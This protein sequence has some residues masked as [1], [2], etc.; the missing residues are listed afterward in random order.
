MIVTTVSNIHQTGVYPDIISPYIKMD[1]DAIIRLLDKESLTFA[2]GALDSVSESKRDRI[3]HL[4]EATV[5]NL[6]ENRIR[7]RIYSAERAR[8]IALDAWDRANPYPRTVD[9]HSS[10][11]KIPIQYRK[12]DVRPINP[13]RQWDLDNWSIRSTNV[14]T[15]RESM[16][17][18][19]A[20]IDRLYYWRQ[21]TDARTNKQNVADYKQARIAFLNSDAYRNARGSYT[22]EYN[23]IFDQL[24]YN[25]LEVLDEPVEDILDLT[26]DDFRDAYINMLRTLPSDADAARTHSYRQVFDPDAIYNHLSAT[27]LR[28][29]A[30]LAT[31]LYNDRRT[32][33][34]GMYFIL[35]YRTVRSD[36][37]SEFQSWV[38]NIRNLQAAYSNALSQNRNRAYLYDDDEDSFMSDVSISVRQINRNQPHVGGFFP[39]Y[40]LDKALND[41][42]GYG[43]MELEY[44]MIDY[45]NRCGIYAPSDPKRKSDMS[46]LH[47]AI[48]ES[49]GVK[50]VHESA[51]HDASAIPVSKL[52]EIALNN[53]IR[54][55]LVDGDTYPPMIGAESDST[56]IAHIARLEGHFF[57][58]IP[59]PEKTFCVP[60]HHRKPGKGNRIYFPNTLSVV[61]FLL[62]HREEYLTPVPMEEAAEVIAGYIDN[63]M[64]I[65]DKITP[66]S[67]A[68]T[69]EKEAK[70]NLQRDGRPAS[71][72]IHDLSVG[73]VFYIE[74]DGDFEASV[75]DVDHIAVGC[76][77]KSEDTEG[78]PP[79]RLEGR[80]CGKQFVDYCYQIADKYD[81]IMKSCVTTYKERVM[82]TEKRRKLDSLPDPNAPPPKS[83]KLAKDKPRYGVYDTLKEVTRWRFQ[84]PKNSVV[85]IPQWMIDRYGYE[86]I[87]FDR[88]INFFYRCYYHNLGYDKAYIASMFDKIYSYMGTGRNCKGFTASR[89]GRVLYF[90]DNA[91]LIPAKIAEFAKMFGLKDVEK[92][93]VPY[94]FFPPGCMEPDHPD[95]FILSGSE[96]KKMLEMIKPGDREKFIMYTSTTKVNGKPLL[97]AN[98]D[99]TYTFYHKECMMDYCDSDVIIQRQGRI[100]YRKLIEEG[101]NSAYKCRPH[102]DY[103]NSG[104]AQAVVTALGA[105]DGCYRLHGAASE[106]VR[107]FCCPG[108]RCMLRENV[109]QH[110]VGRLLYLDFNSLYPTAQ[111]MIKGCPLG[112]PK[113]LSTL[114]KDRN[115]HEVIDEMACDDQYAIFLRLRITNV[116]RKNPFPILFRDNE[117]LGTR[118]YTDECSED[119]PILFGVD[120]W[121][122]NALREYWGLI[123]E[124]DFTIIDGCY[125]DG[126]RT[127]KLKDAM[128][129]IF[130]MRKEYQ[131]A[132]TAAKEASK[133][134]KE[135]GD[136]TE[137]KRLS[138]IAIGQN[139][140]AGVLKLVLNSVWGKDMQRT[141]YEVTT[142]MSA[143]DVDLK[144]ND[145]RCTIEHISDFNSDGT[146]KLVKSLT[147]KVPNSR[148][149]VASEVLGCSKYLMVRF[150]DILNRLK[151]Y[152]AYTDTDSAIIEASGYKAVRE[153]FKNLY[154]FDIHGESEEYAADRKNPPG[155]LHPDFKPE[156]IT[157]AIEFIGV[158]KKVYYLK[159]IRADGSEFEIY[160]FKGMSEPEKT[161]PR[162]CEQNG[163]TVRDFFMKLLHGETVNVPQVYLYSKP[164][165]EMDPKTWQ[166]S[167]NKNRVVSFNFKGPFNYVELPDRVIEPVGL[168]PID[169]PLYKSKTPVIAT[170]KC[171]GCKKKAILKDGKLYPGPCVCY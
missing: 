101:L 39:Y 49:C 56:P 121:I 45:M 87:V 31:T 3:N 164:C 111:I 69:I 48:Y 143:A 144:L 17:E 46:C 104:V 9:T 146:L 168:K 134:A 4:I 25:I 171:K 156:D 106:F 145:G 170:P 98:D 19:N 71:E 52:E 83:A 57:A 96:C 86:P 2:S 163:I 127:T 90:R 91:A 167:S 100:A 84:I 169:C 14:D 107:R 128:D 118:E 74:I 131:R 114:P 78:L 136:V 59:F 94:D 99:G 41:T 7:T 24:A 155:T 165:F 139:A 158:G 132:C 36:V 81:N 20:R 64:I 40:I 152:C 70:L 42:A 109:K 141:F 37:L 147:A 51:V 129:Q 79:I 47:R 44:Y 26:V 97:S 95:H 16:S 63:R 80:S 116:P 33:S 34:R 62:K 133:D 153:E 53:N 43:Y 102:S 148:A 6:A 22:R 23:E 28:D 135:A 160:K 162:Y 50:I 1:S 126:G 66:Y 82:V 113:L 140:L 138:D 67:I 108:G 88:P 15:R 30:A 122:Y 38:L 115:I 161:I 5:R 13:R 125:F 120:R 61:K 157:H 58:N 18:Q 68:L 112:P 77:V 137:S 92:G 75:C 54:I 124:T 142:I 105:Y 123:P 149:H 166:Y 150:M 55:K 35:H 89:D 32:G 29:L 10:W 72:A 8:D 27:M 103:T 151:V 11:N 12:Y 93:V 159:C 110:V 73:D 76:S 85:D 130:W 154:G 60:K 21:L 119:D 117:A 65:G